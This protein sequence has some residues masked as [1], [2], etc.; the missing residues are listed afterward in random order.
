MLFHSLF[1][2]ASKLPELDIENFN[3]SLVF[4]FLGGGS[5]N[6]GGEMIF[7]NVDR[8]AFSS[9]LKHPVVGPE[10]GLDLMLHLDHRSAYT[11]PYANTGHRFFTSPA[12]SIEYEAAISL[13]TQ[14]PFDESARCFALRVAESRDSLGFVK[15]VA[16]SFMARDMS[17]AMRIK[18]RNLLIHFFDSFEDKCGVCLLRRLVHLCP[19]PSLAGLL[20]DVLRGKVMQASLSRKEQSLAMCEGMNC[21]SS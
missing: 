14:N 7:K 13:L 20:L 17:N 16:D 11:S 2:L 9:M 18:A 19:S 4:P 12:A 1:L 6:G 5:K 21:R 8:L 3:Y 15:L 10:E